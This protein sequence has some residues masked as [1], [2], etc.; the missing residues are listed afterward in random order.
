MFSRG[1]EVWYKPAC[2]EILK[3]NRR[4]QGK[5]SSQLTLCPRALQ[6][7]YESYKAFPVTVCAAS[8]PPSYAA[9]SL[10]VCSLFPQGK[11]LCQHD[12]AADPPSNAVL[13][14]WGSSSSCSNERAMNTPNFFSHPG[15]MKDNFISASLPCSHYVTDS[16]RTGNEIH[17][18]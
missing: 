13:R 5:V 1:G 4:N 11:Y 9:P 7:F 16:H 3:S 14:V 8:F 15:S 6:G 12:L 10:P 18:F 2:L 17:I